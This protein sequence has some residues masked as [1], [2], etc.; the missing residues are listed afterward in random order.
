MTCSTRIKFVYCPHTYFHSP[1]I[2]RSRGII[3]LLFICFNP[4]F[5]NF[6]YVFCVPNEEMLIVDW[7]FVV[8]CSLVLR[9]VY[10]LSIL[11]A[12]VKGL[13]V[14][15]WGLFCCVRMKES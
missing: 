13:I 6:I 14:F 12:L 8:S 5:R 15:E 11:L 1:H 2:E 7:S 9:L 10:L 4:D 3:F